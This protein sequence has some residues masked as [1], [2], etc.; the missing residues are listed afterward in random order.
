[1]KLLLWLQLAQRH[2]GGGFYFGGVFYFGG[3]TRSA[4]HV[5][6]GPDLHAHG[7][8]R[9]PA[10]LPV[11][12]HHAVVGAVLRHV[13]R[14]GSAHVVPAV[15]IGRVAAVVP[16]AAAILSGALFAGVARVPGSG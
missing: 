16:P 13:A 5:E 11:H 7:L 15:G 4:G 2:F 6:V 14:V 8:E 12:P 9:V 3:S 10:S 1:M